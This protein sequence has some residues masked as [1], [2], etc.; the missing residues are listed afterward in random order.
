[1]TNE[2]V[3]YVL[4]CVRCGR[5]QWSI[6]L[7]TSSSPLTR[8]VGGERD[9]GGCD[10]ALSLESTAT[11]SVALSLESGETSTALGACNRGHTLSC[12]VISH[13]ICLWRIY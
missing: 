1:M 6:K 12:V 2:G 8:C 10:D 5:P 9:E 3:Q 13:L 7:L 4:C 11:A